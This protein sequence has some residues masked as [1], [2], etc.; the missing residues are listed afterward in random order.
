MLFFLRMFTLLQGVYR[1]VAGKT[2]LG[3]SITA[4]YVA[5]A[6]AVA[7]GLNSVFLN[8][9][10]QGLGAILLFIGVMVAL[11][12]ILS[13]FCS[14]GPLIRNGTGAAACRRC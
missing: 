2:L 12:G 11:R 13:I 8:N 4:L 9:S 5:Q 7:K 14:W 1:H 10:L 3:I 6:F